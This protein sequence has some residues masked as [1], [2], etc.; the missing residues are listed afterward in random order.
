M[1]WKN[2]LNVVQKQAIPVLNIVQNNRW[3]PIMP[4]RLDPARLS[5]MSM[6]L[7]VPAATASPAAPLSPGA[8]SLI[9]RAFA[10]LEGRAPVDY[11]VH[12]LGLGAGGTGAQANPK[13]RSWRHPAS[14]IKAAVVLKCAGVTDEARADQQYVD[15]LLALARGFPRPP[16]LAILAF[17]YRYARDGGVDRG[18]SEFFTPSEYV[19]RLARR[20]PQRFLPVV[21]VHPY[22][23][24]ALKRL[25]AYA[26]AGARLVKWLPNAQGMDPSDPAIDPYYRTMVRLG[27][28]LLCHTGH[29]SS[30]AAGAQRLG[31]P[32]LLRRPLECGVTVVMAH[33][34]N[35]G[36][37][38]DLD[39]P[40]KRA[41]NFDLF[42]RLMDES[43]FRERL[44]GDISTVTQAM[45]SRNDL[46]VLLARTDLHSRL[47]NGSDYPLPAV[48]LF[49]LPQ[50]LRRSGCITAGEC[51]H[52]GE[53]S[54]INSLL[55]DF[56][57]KR[58]LRHPKT[59]A[60]FPPDMFTAHPGLAAITEP[61]QATAPA[62]GGN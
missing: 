14:R 46:H 39:R 11:H 6:P 15:R 47:V 26:G 33:A 45:R 19:L 1:W 49:I 22:D 5:G 32:L 27:M 13:L 7:D 40:G 51:R 52:L 48:G 3:R 36:S 25:E 58:T 2:I 37:S 28:T 62:A 50:L 24:K 41:R 20:C 38:E 54:R 34:G 31:N 10:D 56:V 9:D 8:R 4:Y 29:E 53:I 12:V 16:K 60:Q 43:G 42:L 55:F 23:P 18:G 21:S 59:G 30:V 44:F 35:R 57:L 17:D 61:T